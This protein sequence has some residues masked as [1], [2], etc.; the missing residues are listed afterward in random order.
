[1]KIGFLLRFAEKRM[2]IGIFGPKRAK[3][4]GGWWKIHNVNL[5]NLYSSP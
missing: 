3:V 5:H 1:V 2:L 4:T